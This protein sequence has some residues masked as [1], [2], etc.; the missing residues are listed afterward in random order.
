MVNTQKNKPLRVLGREIRGFTGDRRG[1]VALLAAFS[2]VPLVATVG[3]AT[4]SARGYLLNNRL[5]EAID[6]AALAA[7]RDE[8]DETRQATL[9]QYFWA[10]FPADY[11]G[12]TTTLSDIDPLPGDQFEVSVSATMPNTFLQIINIDTTT[13]N[14]AVIVQKERRG[15]ELVLVMDNTGSMRSNDKMGDMKEAAAELIQILYGSE[16]TIEDFWVG[17]VPYAATVNVGTAHADWL[18]IGSLN[19]RHSYFIDPAPGEYYTP[20]FSDSG[21]SY[22]ADRSY[23]RP[24]NDGGYDANGVAQAADAV[25]SD[26]G[27]EPILD[28][29]SFASDMYA[30]GDFGQVGYHS[31]AS[32]WKGCVEAR[33]TNGR[34]QTDETYLAERF[35]P[36]FYA[37]ASDNAWCRVGGEDGAFCDTP[38]DPPVSGTRE[39]LI[40]LD[41]R[42]AAENEGHGPNL[43]CPPAIT[44]LVASRDTVLDAIDEMEPWHRGGTMGNLG[45]VWGWRALSPRW[46]GDWSGSPAQL[47][48]DYDTPLMDKVVIMLTDGENQFFDY[49]GGGPQGSDYTA[50]GRRDEDNITVGDVTEEL[51]DRMAATC[52]AMKDEG[53]ILYTITFAL[54]DGDTQDLYRNCATSSDHYFNSPSGDELKTAFRTIADQLSNLRLAQ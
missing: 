20:R 19:T 21:D 4:D 49:E 8:N 27:Y 37:P 42:N 3:V 48:L 5:Q 17:L 24:D 38:M 53:I 47:P 13:I 14:A 26:H 39:L 18:M 40:Q 10:N 23:F 12:A 50:Y 28:T 29:D 30:L 52:E 6:I 36:F 44:P 7:A 34:D 31:Y 2:L 45:L 43:G 51:N 9:E 33:W 54:S 35:I 22:W 1:N 25:G 41:Q 15:M 46:R 16:Q 11:L 32:G